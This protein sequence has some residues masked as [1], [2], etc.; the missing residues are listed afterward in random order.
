MLTNL[1]LKFT[2][3]ITAEN[4]LTLAEGGTGRWTHIKREERECKQCAG[5][6]M[7][8][9]E[10]V[11]HMVFKCPNYDDIRADFSCLDFSNNNLNEFLEQQQTQLGSFVKKCEEQHRVL[12]PPP[13]R[14]HRRRR[15][16]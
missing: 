12:N 14:R 3:T 9:V 2:T 7:N 6:E 15:A 11:E 8:T 13:P 16:S 10:T 4:G 1:G 5:K